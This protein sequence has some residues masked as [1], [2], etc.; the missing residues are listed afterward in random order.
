MTDPQ[1][2]KPDRTTET[3]EEAKLPRKGWIVLPL[4][5]VL[6]LA[7]VFGSMELLARQ[8]LPEEGALFVGACMVINNPLAGLQAI[9][10]S[11]CKEKAAEGN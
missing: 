1:A 8:I 3:M 9:P 6:T 7:F 2:V 11:V 4:L 5:D 10:N